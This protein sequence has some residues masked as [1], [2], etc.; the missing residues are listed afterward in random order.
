MTN[1][2]TGP[3]DTESYNDVDAV[4]SYWRTKRAWKQARPYDMALPYRASYVQTTYAKGWGTHEDGGFAQN[5][6]AHAGHAPW[7]IYAERLE[8][9]QSTVLTARDRAR[10][11]FNGRVSQTAEMAV[12]LAERRKSMAMITTRLS[13][14]LRFVKRLKR[15]DVGGALQELSINGREPLIPYGPG[16]SSPRRPWNGNRTRKAAHDVSGLILELSFGWV[17]LVT[18]IFN[19]MEVLDSDVPIFPIRASAAAFYKE[20]VNDGFPGQWRRTCAVDQKVVARVGGGIRVTNP[21]LHLAARLGLVNPASVIWELAP[22]SFVFDYFVNVSEYLAQF[23]EFAGIEFI[24]PYE[25]Y[26]GRSRVSQTY[27]NFSGGWTIL[28]EALV[29]ERVPGLSLVKLGIRPPWSISASRA[30][31]S[32]SLLIQQFIKKRS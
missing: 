24:M 30:A 1:P 13:Q 17:P 2:V 8:S 27:T 31:T 25:N 19:A 4:K 11:R 14:M 26:T 21:N 20:V 29:F 32:V 5:A 10:A 3:F 15:G 18:D 22:W 6:N 7:Y 23:T 28:S 16:G 12:A 9:T